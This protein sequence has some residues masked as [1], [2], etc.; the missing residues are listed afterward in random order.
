EVALVGDQLACQITSNVESFALIDRWMARQAEQQ[1]AEHVQLEQTQQRLL[2]VE[3]RHNALLHEM[4]ALH[5]RVAEL[6][7]VQPV[8][9][10]TEQVVLDAPTLKAT[11]HVERATVEATPATPLKEVQDRKR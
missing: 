1:E 5:A 3:A 9:I 4:E 10:T 11:R 2:G 8:R 6:A 7:Q